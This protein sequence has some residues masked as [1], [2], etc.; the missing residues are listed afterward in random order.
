[1]TQ[2]N[3]LPPKPTQP[4][5]KKKDVFQSLP[6]PNHLPA[7]MPTP[8]PARSALARIQQTI[9]SQAKLDDAKA[10]TT[11]RKVA[12]VA[13]PNQ[14]LPS[15]LVAPI[16]PVVT[17]KPPAP[18]PAKAP[19]PEL[20]LAA[21]HE[22]DLGPDVMFAGR[23]L[24]TP[25]KEKAN[26][27]VAE[28]KAIFDEEQNKAYLQLST[29]GKEPRTLHVLDFEDPTMDGQFCLIV[30][31]KT[32]Y[33]LSLGDL[34]TTMKFR[35]LLIALRKA[36]VHHASNLSRVNGEEIKEASTSLDHHASVAFEPAVT[37]DDHFSAIPCASGLASAA[38]Q[39]DENAQVGVS[40]DEQL[41]D[42][43]GF[44][45]VT[46]PST[47]IGDISNRLAGLIEQV[48]SVIKPTPETSVEVMQGVEEAALDY[49]SQNFLLGK[50]DP[51]TK[52]HVVGLVH[53]MVALQTMT[54][55]QAVQRGTF[56]PVG[57]LRDPS[58]PSSLLEAQMSSRVEY[59]AQDMENLQGRAVPCPDEI[60]TTSYLPK[61][62]SPV[63]NSQK[64]THAK[65]QT[66]GS[67]KVDNNAIDAEYQVRKP[68]D[69][70]KKQ[71]SGIA[72]QKGWLAGVEETH[73]ANPA[74]GLAAI[75]P[76]SVT[77]TI[78]ETR[79]NTTETVDPTIVEA[80]PNNIE[81]CGDPPTPPQRLDADFDTTM[82]NSDFGAAQHPLKPSAKEYIPM[83]S[84][85]GAQ[86]V[87]TQVFGGSHCF[88]PGAQPQARSKPAVPSGDKF[89]SLA[90]GSGFPFL[91]C[92]NI[93]VAPAPA[94][95]TQSRP[96]LKGLGA[97]RYADKPVAF[98]GYFTG[99]S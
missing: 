35:D 57:P 11:G 65:F 58:Q 22:V 39:V 72:S 69:Q 23:A 14:G 49:W 63:A 5:L 68:S 67:R 27:F 83:A 96:G 42:M 74:G 70:A 18:E 3:S 77:P 54:Q 61:P 51:E 10:P 2:Q 92:R 20:M 21:G 94:G 64:A 12:R 76:S 36:A 45:H 75:T 71:I 41:I 16:P 24:M 79:T 8:P 32:N 50:C 13:I 62:K 7:G 48:M 26:A 37:I 73:V 98:E 15:T 52:T 43:T 80:S 31:E 99:A 40:Q 1:M 59:T 91:D 34:A 95:R 93:E 19:V 86:G 89:P 46:N 25:G 97:S 82:G 78:P 44:Q 38:I 47:L 85:H 81:Q 60:K 56:T 33:H 28:F 84:R 9:W 17:S 30:Y 87:R 4:S 66:R 6:Q 53:H 90:S 55:M 29:R 88:K